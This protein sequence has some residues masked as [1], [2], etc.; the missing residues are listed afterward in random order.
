MKPENKKATLYAFCVGAGIIGATIGIGLHEQYQ[1]GPRTYYTENTIWE[2]KDRY[3]VHTEEFKQ[4]L[5]T[6]VVTPEE[7]DKLNWG[8]SL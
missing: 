3:F 7:R 6:K 4:I 8:R 1:R 5:K 2:A